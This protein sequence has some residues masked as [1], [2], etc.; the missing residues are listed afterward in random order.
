MRHGEEDFEK[1]TVRNLRW[2][3]GNPYGFGVSGRT[4]ADC[5]VLSG[6]RRTA[7]VPGDDVF[8]SF[9]VLKDGLDSPE[10]A[11]CEYGRL[12]GLCGSEGFVHS[13]IRQRFRRSQS[14]TRRYHKA[15]EHHEKR[16]VKQMV[17]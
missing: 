17:K 12:L 11:T 13:R 9:D 15:A 5:I 16:P 6:F 14:R 2:V 1:L 3:V 7:R 4:A 10:T 8:D